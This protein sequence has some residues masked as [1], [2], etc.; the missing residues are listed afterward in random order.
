M[1]GQVGSAC[2][3]AFPGSRFDA[4]G[5]PDPTDR[6]SKSIGDALAHAYGCVTVYPSDGPPY[7]PFQ[8]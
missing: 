6:W 8:Q 2:W 3:R 7:A 4:D 5:L 1:V